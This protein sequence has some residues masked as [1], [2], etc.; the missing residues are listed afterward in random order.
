MDFRFEIWIHRS[1]EEK[2]FFCIPAGFSAKKCIF[3]LSKK[4]N[5]V[6]PLKYCFSLEKVHFQM[7]KPKNACKFLTLKPSDL[8]I[9][10]FPH[11]YM[12]YPGQRTKSHIPWQY[13]PSLFKWQKKLTFLSS[14]GHPVVLAIPIVWI[15]S[16]YLHI[17]KCWLVGW[18]VWLMSR[19]HE[20]W[21]LTRVSIRVSILAPSG[22]LLIIKTI[23]DEIFFLLF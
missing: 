16:E 12:Q 22:K 5:C 21:N 18:L 11:T 1:W 19:V 17:K 15:C 6:T 13:Y 14:P 3:R 2:F 9:Y 8:T 4:I 7:H 23:S 20:W 10:T